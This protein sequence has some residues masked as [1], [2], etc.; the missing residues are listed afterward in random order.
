LSSLAGAGFVIGSGIL[1]S[2]LQTIGTQA[3]VSALMRSGA[4]RFISNTAYSAISATP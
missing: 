1:I 4:I 2:V 3:V